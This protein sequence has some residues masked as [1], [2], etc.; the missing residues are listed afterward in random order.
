VVLA[1]ALPSGGSVRTTWT[2]PDGQAR[3]WAWVQHGFARRGDDLAGLAGLLNRSGFAVV[4]PDIASWRPRRSM[5]DAGWLT[6][7]ALTLGRAVDSGLPQTRGVAADGP[8]VLAGH[9][10]G[11]AVVTHGA[12]CLG[13]RHGAAPV[14]SLILLDPVDTVGGL[15]TAALGSGGVASSVHVHACRPS[16]CNRHGATVGLLDERGWPVTWHPG[17]AH[18][19]PERIPPD[20]QAGSVPAP[21]PWLARVCGELGDPADIA[22]LARLVRAQACADPGRTPP[23]LRP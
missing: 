22:E 13:A 23:R 11:A 17:L 21:S 1:L 8:W 19:D 3:G 7:V 5:H 4:R 9:S 20:A 16:R 10:A 12:A 6:E 14:A 2:A 15:L 18:P